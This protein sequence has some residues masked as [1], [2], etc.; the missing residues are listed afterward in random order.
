MRSAPKCW[1]VPTESSWQLLPLGAQ[2]AAHFVR[3]AALETCRGAAFSQVLPSAVGPP[4]TLKN[5]LRI[6]AAGNCLIQ[7]GERVRNQREERL[8]LSGGGKL[9]HERLQPPGKVVAK[10]RN[11]VQSPEPQLGAFLDKATV[12]PALQ[13]SGS[14]GAESLLRRHLPDP[15]SLGARLCLYGVLRSGQQHY[16]GLGASNERSTQGSALGPVLLSI[17][18]TSVFGGGVL[19]Q[20]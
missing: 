19:L 12:N 7:R 15:T 14:K 3:D 1:R 18:I 6:K 2:P 11:Q 10:L 5:L 13:T 4:L 8:T 9:S 16:K 17:F 20:Q